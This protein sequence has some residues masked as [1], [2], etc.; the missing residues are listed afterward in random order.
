VGITLIPCSKQFVA[1]IGDLDLSEPMA[2]DDLA[3]VREAFKTYAVLVFP[4]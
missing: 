2:A 4:G 3:A 1:E